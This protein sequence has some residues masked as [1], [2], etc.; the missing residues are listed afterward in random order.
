MD[1]GRKHVTIEIYTEKQALKIAKRIQTKN[2]M[3]TYAMRYGN[4]SIKSRI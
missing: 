3:V 2:T 1:E 4:P